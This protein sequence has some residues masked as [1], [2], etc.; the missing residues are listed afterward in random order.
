MEKQ[1]L[2]SDASDSEERMEFIHEGLCHRGEGWH[3]SASRRCPRIGDVVDKGV[4]GGAGDETE[5]TSIKK[6]PLF[7]IYR[8]G[9]GISEGSFDDFPYF[10]CGKGVPDLHMPDG[11]VG[12]SNEDRDA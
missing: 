9:R 2:A 12:L 1:K 10:V 4:V 3:C 11:V 7:L 8:Y 5:D 6:L